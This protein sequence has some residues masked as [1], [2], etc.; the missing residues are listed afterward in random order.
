MII[1]RWRNIKS[2]YEM[3][4]G[5]TNICLSAQIYKKASIYKNILA[6]DDEILWVESKRDQ[7]KIKAC[8]IDRDVVT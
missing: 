4:S 6:S 7:T 3:G 5:I 1:V 8:K 2:S